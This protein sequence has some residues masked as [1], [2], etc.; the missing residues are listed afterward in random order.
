SFEYGRE[1]FLPEDPPESAPSHAGREK[2]EKL[3]AAALGGA[4]IDGGEATP[5]TRFHEARKVDAVVTPGHPG[6]PAGPAKGLASTRGSEV[7]TAPDRQAHAP[8]NRT[9]AAGPASPTTSPVELVVPL[10]MPRQGTRE[11]V[12]RIVLTEDD[13]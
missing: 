1:L 8:G 13:A 2:T 6:G 10:S 4:E 7:A 11:I 3:G 5:A 9:A 12:L